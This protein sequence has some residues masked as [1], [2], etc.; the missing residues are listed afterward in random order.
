MFAEKTRVGSD[1]FPV[2]MVPFFGGR[3]T[4][5]GFQA[6]GYTLLGTKRYPI[7]QGTFEPIKI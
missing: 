3:G 4:F 1:A 2:E 6:G 5:V 7:P